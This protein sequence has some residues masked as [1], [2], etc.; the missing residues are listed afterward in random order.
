MKKFLIFI[1]LFVTVNLFHAQ[2][3]C[4]KFPGG[5]LSCLRFTEA[6]LCKSCS[7]V[8]RVFGEEVRQV[9]PYDVVI[10]PLIGA[11][12]S[13]EELPGQGWLTDST[14]CFRIEGLK[15][16]T[17]HLTG[18]FVGLNTSD[19]VIALQE[20]TDTLRLIL[21]LLYDIKYDYS[22]QL[23]QK[24]IRDGH[25]CLVIVYPANERDKLYKNPF[26]S[27][28]GIS[29][30]GYGTEKGKLI[31][32]LA[33]PNYILTSFNSEVF[34]YLDKKWG[35]N[36]RDEAPKG[37]FGLDKTLNEPRDYDITQIK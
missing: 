28:Y 2:K 31:P 6:N 16:G 1:L 33:I 19:T 20:Q 8:G 15:S 10:S 9:P 14:G 25:P 22:V 27:K 35:R 32:Y 23:A 21:P 11:Y 5:I 26:W 7:L 29:Y 18:S 34:S 13:F 24:N 3:E 36:W 30:M 12:I 37:I 17:Y 4:S